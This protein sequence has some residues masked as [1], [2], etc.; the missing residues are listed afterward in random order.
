MILRC[1]VVA[2]LLAP[3]LLLTGPLMAQS[4]Q[5]SA[6]PAPSEDKELIA[7]A[8][9][10]TKEAA[11]KYEFT[12]DGA[13]GQLPQLVAEPVLRWSNPSAGEIHGNVFLWTSGGRPAVVGSIFK[14]FSPHTHMSHEFHSLA[15]QPLRGKF[16]GKEVWVSSEP[17]VRFT[18]LAAAP[19]PATGK[20]QRLQQM[21]ELA[22]ACAVTKRE[23]DG[24]LSE[25]RLLTQPI[26]RY[27]APQAGLIDGALFAF[28]QGTDPDLFLLLE[29][30]ESGGKSAWQFAACRM[31]SVAFTL[32]YNDQEIWSVDV[33]PWSDVNGHRQP[34]TSFLHKMP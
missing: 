24:S 4:P 33:L 17:G 12:L 27:E 25:L 7:A 1:C 19:P 32:R 15:Q 29:A 2:W 3:A 18:G 10:L 8:L 9:K 16:G 13:D 22:R 23:R 30:R 6:A 21:R 31:N 14:W 11:A 20:L 5:P 34:Y 26:F 28:V